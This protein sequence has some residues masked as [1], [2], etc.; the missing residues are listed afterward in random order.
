MGAFVYIAAV[1]PT[2]PDYVGSA[3]G[4]DL[5]KRIAEHEAGTYPGYS[6]F[7]PPDIG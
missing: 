5:T 6:L 4:D 1:H 2:A 3:T 7:P